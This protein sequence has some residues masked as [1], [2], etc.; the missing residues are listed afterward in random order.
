MSVYTLSE[1]MVTQPFFV[2]NYL[3]SFSPLAT[4]LEIKMQ[5]CKMGQSM[6]FS[7][8]TQLNFPQHKEKR[9]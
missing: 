3:R 7:K 8:Y 4:P 1:L 6:G 5:N 9:L 2:V